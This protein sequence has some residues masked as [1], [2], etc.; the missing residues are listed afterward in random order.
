MNFTFT[1]EEKRSPEANQ[2]VQKGWEIFP[3]KQIAT[4]S[5]QSEKS[6]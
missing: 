2:F 4:S 3:M 6:A 1:P 5:G